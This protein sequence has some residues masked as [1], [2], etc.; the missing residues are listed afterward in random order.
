MDYNNYIKVPQEVARVFERMGLPEYKVIQEE[1]DGIV[2]TAPIELCRLLI[3]M[4]LV[5]YTADS[6]WRKYDLVYTNTDGKITATF[7]GEDERIIN[8]GVDVIDRGEEVI[9]KLLAD[10]GYVI[11]TITVNSQAKAVNAE[12]L[13]ETLTEGATKSYNITAVAKEART[14]TYSLGAY[15]TGSVPEAV[16][17][18]VGSV[19]SIEFNPIPK[20]HL[21]KFVV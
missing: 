8:P 6:G 10:N 21:Y 7:T 18:G 12:S 11:D 16:V 13:D 3:R 4:G 1:D 5:G 14:L 15:G 2:I 19:V 9:M 20:R 17:V